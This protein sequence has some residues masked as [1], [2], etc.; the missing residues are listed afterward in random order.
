MN[1]KVCIVTGANSGLGKAPALKFA[2]A[3]ATIVLA[4]R[5]R[6]RGEA[7]QAEIT[8]ATG[9]EALGCES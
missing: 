9:K 8:A 7:A 1:D 2:K 4:C 3:G 5:N 6:A